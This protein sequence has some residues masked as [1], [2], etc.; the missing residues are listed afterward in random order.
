MKALEATPRRT[1]RA[2]LYLALASLD[3]MSVSIGFLLASGVR[4]GIFYTGPDQN[5]LGIVV[6][7]FV[8][9]SVSTQSYT[10]RSLEAPNTGIRRALRALIITATLILAV[11]F[12]TKASEQYSRAVFALG[13]AFS[14]LLIVLVRYRFGRWARA[15][16]GGNFVDVVLLRDE[17]SVTPARGQIVVSADQLNITSESNDPLALERIGNLFAHCD[18]VVVAAPAHRRVQW[19]RLLKGAG[20]NVEVLMPELDALGPLQLGRYAGGSTLLISSG[21]LNL[22]DRVAKRLLDLSI[23][24]PAVLL[25]SPL[26]LILGLAIK[27]ESPGGVFFKQERVGLGNRRFLIWKLRT[28]RVDQADHAGTRSASRDD[29]RITRMGRFLRRTS[30]DELPQLINVLIGNMSIVGPRP[31]ALA[32]TAED[33]LFW[34]IDDRY[35]ERGAVKPGITGLAQVRGHRGATSTRDDVVQRV[36]ADLEYLAGWTL[37]RDVAIIFRTMRVLIHEKAF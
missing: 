27:L 21:P 8:L 35:W 18:R 10:L 31:H 25:A 28:M 36:Q 22:R 12:Y 9:I 37:W 4:H 14:G 33:S 23:A 17:V 2:R 26:L 20:A 7:A 30:I 11:M 15:R 32:S 1:V 13:V 29:D 5:F 24:V 6:P 34:H 16:H 19:S 3:V